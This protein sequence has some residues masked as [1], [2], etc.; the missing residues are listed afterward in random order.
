MIAIPALDLHAPLGHPSLALMARAL[1]DLGFARLQITDRQTT[2][3]APSK[4]PAVEDILRDTAARVQVD[5]VDTTTDI[6][7]LLRI[8]I[9]QVIVGARGIDEPEWLADVAQLYPETISLMTDVHDRRVVRRGWVRTLPV[10]IL[11]LVE[12]LND[13]AL[14]EI[15]VSVKSLDARDRARELALLED[16]AERSHF[17]VLVSGAVSSAD[18]CRALEHRG[19]AGAVIDANRLLGGDLDG[20]EIA[21]EFGA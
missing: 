17:P 5:G 19:L 6:D 1:D 8:G 18:D 21:Q 9:A 3:H 13:F 2:A 15:I 11:D 12:E 16:V 7:Q 4:L 14:R 20:R 10:D